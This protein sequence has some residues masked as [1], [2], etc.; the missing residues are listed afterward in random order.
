MLKS[1]GF[2][3]FVGVS[4]THYVPKSQLPDGASDPDSNKRKVLLIGRWKGVLQQEDIPLAYLKITDHL[5]YLGCKLY[6][7]YVS[8]RRE[9]GD[10]LKKTVREQMGSWKSGKFLPLTS[11]P[12]SNCYANPHLPGTSNFANFHNQLLPEL[13]IQMACSRS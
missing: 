13:S 11:R 3:P 5:D 12:W 10:I 2:V 4:L 1:H 7:D 9:N 8:T 6:A